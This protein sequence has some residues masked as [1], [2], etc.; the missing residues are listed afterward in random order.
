MKP[1]M[2][3]LLEAAV[4]RGC[5]IQRAREMLIEQAPLYLKLFGF[6][7]VPATALRSELSASESS[8]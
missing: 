6:G 3:P 2:T 4:A 8:T 1:D 5:A 7:G